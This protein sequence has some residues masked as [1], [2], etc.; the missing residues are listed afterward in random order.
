M[1]KPAYDIAI[2]L[3]R[4]HDRWL[5]AK[6]KSG[7]HAGGLWEFPGGKRQPRETF[8][9]AALRELREEC[10]VEAVAERVL[11]SV[12]HEYADRTVRLVPVV[13]RHERGEPLPRAAELCRWV[14]A[15]ELRELDMPAAN[16]A[17]L[18][19]MFADEGEALPESG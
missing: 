19:L 14:T 2:A 1:R 5:V 4:R 13:C 17:L 8:A 18:R 3:L 15:A 7:V 10:A 9:Q 11:R 6:R 16:A 12:E